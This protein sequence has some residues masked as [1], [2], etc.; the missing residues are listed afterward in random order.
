MDTIRIN[1]A[2]L[3]VILLMRFFTENFRFFPNFVIR[4]LSNHSKLLIWFCLIVISTCAWVVANYKFRFRVDKS[5]CRKD[6]YN[7]G[8]QE[9]TVVK[10]LQMYKAKS[11]LQTNSL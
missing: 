8:Q 11:I 4:L 5:L 3:K 2:T 9:L 7:I 6:S 1:L 10:R